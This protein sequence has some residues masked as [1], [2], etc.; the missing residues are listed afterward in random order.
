LYLEGTWRKG[1]LRS[2]PRHQ[3][4]Q[5]ARRGSSTSCIPEQPFSPD[6][7]RPPVAC[8]AIPSVGSAQTNLEAFPVQEGALASPECACEHQTCSDAGPVTAATKTIAN[9]NKTTHHQQ[10]TRRT[11]GI[12]MRMTM[13][14]RFK[15]LRRTSPR[16]NHVARHVQERSVSNI[17]NFLAQDLPH[18]TCTT[19]GCTKEAF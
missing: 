4:R 19:A 1:I 9:P 17:V 15:M 2:F 10:T 12:R 3:W 6:T 5:A 7:Y 11:T 13:M 16:R 8:Q 14:S 18:R